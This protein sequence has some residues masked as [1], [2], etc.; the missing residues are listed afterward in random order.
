MMSA[1]PVVPSEAY[2]LGG[3]E[4]LLGGPTGMGRRDTTQSGYSETPEDKRKRRR[5]ENFMLMAGGQQPATTWGGGAQNFTSSIM[6][7]LMLRQLGSTPSVST[8]PINDMP[9]GSNRPR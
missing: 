2:S 8:P 1:L 7:A 9:Y 6:G 5:V 4:S 3:G